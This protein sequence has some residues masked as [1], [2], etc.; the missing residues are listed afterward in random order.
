MSAVDALLEMVD[1]Q[2]SA[3]SLPNSVDALFDMIDERRVSI[4]SKSFRP[5]SPS[6]GPVPIKK[7][8]RTQGPKK[9]R[10]KQVPRRKLRREQEEVEEPEEEAPP[11]RVNF[12][13]IGRSSMTS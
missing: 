11:S 7:I 6:V 12:D 4:G 8:R 3:A 13:A 9:Y 2:P 5:R 1:D 10:R